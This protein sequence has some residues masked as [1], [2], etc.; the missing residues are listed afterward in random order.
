V[1]ATFFT[2][3][4]LS[5]VYFAIVVSY[6]CKLFTNSASVVANSLASFPPKNLMLQWLAIFFLFRHFLSP[7][8]SSKIRT[9]DLRTRHGWDTWMMVLKR[10]KMVWPR[11]RSYFLRQDVLYK[12]LC[13]SRL[14]NGI[15]IFLF[16]LNELE[17]CFSYHLF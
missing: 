6:S 14:M 15:E 11:M 5:V 10:D 7:G 1:Y 4:S 17:R 9:L 16:G 8:A 3:Y 2:A 13:K 12:I